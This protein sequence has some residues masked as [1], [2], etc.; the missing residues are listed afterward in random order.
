[1]DERE[2]RA[3]R[4]SLNIYEVLLAAHARRHEVFD[5]V[6]TAA[7]QEEAERRLRVLLSI[8][9]GVPGAQPIM[10]M[11]MS[12][13]TLDSRELIADQAQHLRSLLSDPA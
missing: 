7:D 9:E 11:A 4:E 13:W 8:P 2:E 10:D 5:V 3:A 6:C 12:K 1:M